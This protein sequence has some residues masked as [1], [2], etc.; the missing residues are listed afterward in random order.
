MK[1]IF[2]V[3]RYNRVKGRDESQYPPERGLEGENFKTVDQNSFWH[4][5]AV[6]SRRELGADLL[7]KPLPAP[8]QLKVSGYHSHQVSLQFNLQVHHPVWQFHQMSYTSMFAIPLTETDTL[9]FL[10]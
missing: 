9:H 7:M 10:F 5:L 2:C 3:R 1:F 6:C 4:Q 8:E